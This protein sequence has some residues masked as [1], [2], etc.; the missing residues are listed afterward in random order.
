MGMKRINGFQHVLSEIS[1]DVG[2]IF[3]ENFHDFTDRPLAV[4]ELPHDGR[5][6]VHIDSGGGLG[7]EQQQ[8]TVHFLYAVTLYLFGSPIDALLTQN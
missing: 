3:L 7:M 8:F 4:A 6:L 2:E 5:G 1:R